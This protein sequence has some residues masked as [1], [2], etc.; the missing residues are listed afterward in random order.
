MRICTFVYMSVSGYNE[1]R[2]KDGGAGD[3]QKQGK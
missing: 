2:I 3:V 1:V